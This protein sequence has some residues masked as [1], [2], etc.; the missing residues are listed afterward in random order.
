MC[1]C[2]DHDSKFSRWTGVWPGK[3]EAVF[4]GVDLN[5]FGIKYSDFFF[6]KPTGENDDR[7]DEK[8]PETVGGEYEQDKIPSEKI[9]EM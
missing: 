3:A 9:G 2:T 7:R 6:I 4:L 1:N 5:E 8:K